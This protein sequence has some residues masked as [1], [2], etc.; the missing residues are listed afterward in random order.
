[1]DVQ[2]VIN[3]RKISL[4]KS[5]VFWNIMPFSP[6]K[7]NRC[8][9]GLCR[10]HLQGWKTNQARNQCEADNKQSRWRWQ[11]LPKLLLNFDG[12]HGITSHKTE[13][14]IT[15]AVRTTSNPTISLMSVDLMLNISHT[16]SDAQ[17]KSLVNFFYWWMV[18]LTLN[19]M[20]M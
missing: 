1:M 9:G 12:L 7:I 6:L 16:H 10:L 2:K 14:F 4:K 13:F 18:L 17:W 5:S 20:T 11:A 8:F 15:T 3:W 19:F